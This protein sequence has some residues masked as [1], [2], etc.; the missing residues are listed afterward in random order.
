MKGGFKEDAGVAYT[1]E[2]GMR[3]FGCQSSHPLVRQLCANRQATVTVPLEA[4]EEAVGA[5]GAGDEEEEAE[6]DEAE[7]VADVFAPVAFCAPSA[8]YS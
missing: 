5:N 2:G 7:A 6:G 3:S 1:P 4:E 8:L